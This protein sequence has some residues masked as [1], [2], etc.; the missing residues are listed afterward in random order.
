LVV[1][2]PMPRIRIVLLP[3]SPLLNWT[4]GVSLSVSSWSRAPRASS[5]APSSTETVPA[6]SRCRSA[7]LL[8]VM[9]TA[10]SRLVSSS[11][12]AAADGACCAA[13]GQ[14]ATRASASALSWWGVLIACLLLNGAG[15]DMST[16]RRPGA[17]LH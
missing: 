5:A 13:T 9:T 1:L 4:P 17:H 7:R 15:D 6:T 8:A 11:W 2:V 10:S 16:L 14:A 3:A 12:G